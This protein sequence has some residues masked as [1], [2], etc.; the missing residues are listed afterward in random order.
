MLEQVLQ[1]QS[2]LPDLEW[3]L[4]LAIWWDLDTARIH[5]LPSNVEKPLR[6]RSKHPGVVYPWSILYLLSILHFGMFWKQFKPHTSQKLTHAYAKAGFQVFASINLVVLGIFIYDSV[7]R[8]LGL[9]KAVSRTSEGTRV[10]RLISRYIG[11]NTR[12]FSRLCRPS[13]QSYKTGKVIISNGLLER[14]MVHNL[15]ERILKNLR[16]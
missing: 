16:R 14:L 6:F 1:P 3:G 2:R 8:L 11:A 4:P 15:S 12:A 9:P 13:I 5:F 7:D 10:A